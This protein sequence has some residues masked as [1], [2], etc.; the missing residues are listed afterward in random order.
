[1]SSVF[2]PLPKSTKQFYLR[3]KT[4][5]SIMMM[6][7]TLWL[8][9]TLEQGK[10]EFVAIFPRNG[11]QFILQNDKSCMAKKCD[12]FFTDKINGQKSIISDTDHIC[13]NLQKKKREVGLI[14]LSCLNL[15]L[16]SE[17]AFTPPVP[18]HCR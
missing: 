10:K 13:Q 1:M 4:K 9:D 17:G 16:K 7:F 11:L 15:A 2:Y 18:S 14:H 5:D 12:D 3:L 8:S 6:G